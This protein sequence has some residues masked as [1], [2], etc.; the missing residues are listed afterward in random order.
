MSGPTLPICLS[1]LCLS[2]AHISGCGREQPSPDTSETTYAVSAPKSRLSANG[3]QLLRGSPEPLPKSLRLHLAHL[4]QRDPSSFH[5]QRTQRGRAADGAVWVFFEGE[6]LCLAQGGVGAIACSPA[7]QASQE[8]L[9]LGVFTPPSTHIP[10]PH[11][12]LVIGLAPNGIGQAV[13]SIGKTRHV[14]RVHRNLYSA[15]GNRP[16]LIRRLLPLAQ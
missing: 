10:R 14:V 7:A 1:L 15:S 16:I 3:F 11:D 12:F 2:T 8:G 5:P 9:T 13:L 6:N 4:L